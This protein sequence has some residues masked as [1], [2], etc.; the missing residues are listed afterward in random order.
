M[1]EVPPAQG[2]IQILGIVVVHSIITNLNDMEEIWHHT[3]YNE[4][5]VAPEEHPAQGLPG[6]HDADQV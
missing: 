6:A 1:V 4:L 2:G 3:F 5:K